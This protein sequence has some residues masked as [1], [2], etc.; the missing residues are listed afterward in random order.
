M[1]SPTRDTLYANL[2]SV[3]Q[4]LGY[5]SAEGLTVNFANVPG[6]A[7]AA[8]IVASGKADM[9][10]GS[11]DGVFKTRQLGGDLKMVYVMNNNLQY[12]PAV[13]INSPIKDLA[14][15]KG[16]KL[17]VLSLSMGGIPYYRAM[18][19]AGGLDPDKDVTLIA[20]GQ[21]AQALGAL[22]SGIVDAL[23]EWDVEYAAEENSGI[24]YRK[25]L[26]PNFERDINNGMTSSVVT[27]DAFIRAHPDAVEKYLRAVAKATVFCLRNE[28]ACVRIHWNV[29]PDMKPQ[30]ADSSAALQNAVHVL[31]ARYAWYAYNRF[32]GIHRWGDTTDQ[33][34][35]NTAAL[36]LKN[37]DINAVLPV[38]D[39]FTRQFLGFANNFN[40]TAIAK[41][42]ETYK[43]QD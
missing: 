33:R 36:L 17:G 34:I 28:A 19:A 32:P 26:P 37:G 13:P 18:L 15:L 23:G 8:Q 20:V 31:D 6:G 10:F 1:S 12:Y 11:G 2:T 40:E 27:T 14:G 5:F 7:A 25:L 21:G 35:K 42:A 24:R 38:S 29:Y 39:Y 30:D 22:R 41:Q 3:P 9:Y 43:P 16:K 4:K